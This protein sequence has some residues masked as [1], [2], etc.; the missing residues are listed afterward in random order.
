MA[1]HN[2][3][4]AAP[5][6]VPL[7]ITMASGVHAIASSIVLDVATPPSEI[8]ISGE[9]G[10]T[11]LRPPENGAPLLTVKS[12]AP[13]VHLF[14]LSLP[15]GAVVRVE[16]GSVEIDGCAF[17]GAPEVQ[18]R[19]MME[20]F[21]RFTS[22]PPV[23]PSTREITIAPAVQQLA[24]GLHSQMQTRTVYASS[25]FA[26]STR[27]L[28]GGGRRL[29]HDNNNGDGSSNWLRLDGC[30]NQC[31]DGGGKGGGG[32]SQYAQDGTCDDGGPGSAYAT[33]RL[34]T[35]CADCGARAPSPPPPPLT[36]PLLPPPSNPP[37]SPPPS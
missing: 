35:D 5:V 17:D 29:A 1:L 28:A 23:R 12:R 22:P 34:G 25:A 14:G 18:A 7:R 6:G 37:P 31:N 32:V 30:N 33:C 19:R 11:S 2:A 13:P 4:Q 15:A 9:P 27:V 26:D 10:R 16:G 20:L 21:Q 24:A 8:W 36:P 3:L